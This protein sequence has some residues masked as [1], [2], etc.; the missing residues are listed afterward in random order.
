MQLEYITPNDEMQIVQ[1]RWDGSVEV[2]NFKSI[3]S[4]AHS[5]IHYPNKYDKKIK[6]FIEI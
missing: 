2:Y 4:E 5:H 3:Y 1:E 6:L